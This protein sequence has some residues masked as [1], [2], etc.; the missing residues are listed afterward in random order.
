MRVLDVRLKLG[1]GAA[2]PVDVD[3]VEVASAVAGR[4][5]RGS[6]VETLAGILAGSDS[7]NGLFCSRRMQL[8]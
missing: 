6:P 5:E 8:V 3:V 7:G 4:D 1:E 2:V